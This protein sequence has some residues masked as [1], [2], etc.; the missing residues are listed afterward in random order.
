MQTTVKLNNNAHSPRKMRLLAD[1]VRGMQVD[2][3]LYTLKVHPKKMYSVILE[4]LVRSAIASWS[5]KYED[6]RMEDQN[7]VISMVKVDGA[8]VLKRIQPA[9]QGRA[10]RVRTRY[11]HITL[12]VAP[13]GWVAPK[14]EKVTK[15]TAE[16]VAVA[17]AP[18]KKAKASSKKAVE[19]ATE[20][21]AKKTRTRKTKEE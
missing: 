15:A 17:E 3:A 7:L 5:L 19:A 9:P 12:S 16:V 6:E 21:A 1:L 10:H 20:A 14:P 8:K 18:A 13:S 11:N 4:K 2:K